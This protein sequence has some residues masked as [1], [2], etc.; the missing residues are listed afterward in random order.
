LSCHYFN[1]P[2]RQ[3]RSTLKFMTRDHHCCSSRGGHL[4]NLIEFVT[5]GSIKSCVGLVE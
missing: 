3:L 1:L 4:E 2:S 5:T